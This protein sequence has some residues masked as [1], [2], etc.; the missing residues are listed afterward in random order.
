MATRLLRLR[1]ADVSLRPRG[2]SARS[3]VVT[4]VA[5]ALFA[6][7][8][9]S[10][11]AA[12]EL[13]QETTQQSDTSQGSFASRSG[14][15]VLRP[16]A[17]SRAKS[18]DDS[19][20]QLRCRTESDWLA[21]SCLRLP[22]SGARASSTD[23]GIGGEIYL[24]GET[25][26]YNIQHVKPNGTIDSHKLVLNGHPTVCGQNVYYNLEVV[27]GG[28]RHHCAGPGHYTLIYFY[29]HVIGSNLFRVLES[30]IIV[31][32]E[33]FEVMPA[34]IERTDGAGQLGIVN[35]KLPKPFVV[36]LRDFEGNV[37]KFPIADRRPNYV[38]TIA[39]P[40]GASGATLSPA[41]PAPNNMG[42]ATME[43]YL[44]NKVGA[45]TVSLTHPSA[46]VPVDFVAFAQE[47]VEPEHDATDEEEDGEITDP[48]ESRADPISIATGNNHHVETDYPRS[49]LSPL[50]FRRA[51]NSLGAKSRLTGNHWT[52]T[53]DR[54]V[55]A[56]QSAAEPLRL[57]RPDGRTIRFSN[58]AG[59]LVAQPHF[60]GRLEVVSGGWRY[61]DEQG[62][63]ETFD[64]AGKLLSIADLHGRTQTVAYDRR[65]GRMATVTT[66]TGESL[67]FQYNTKGRLSGLTDHTGRVWTYAYDAWVNL[68]QVK[69]PDGVYRTHHHERSGN[70]WLLTGVSVGRSA[71]PAGVDRQVSWSYDDAGRAT[72]NHLHNG[73]AEL[74]RVNVTYFPDGTR[75][76]DYADGS[77]ESFTTVVANGRTWVGAVRGPAFGSTGTSDLQ[78]QFDPHMNVLSS[79]RHGRSTAFGPYDSKRQPAFRIDAA[80]TPLERRADFSY[81]ARFIRRPT[82]VTEPSVVAGRQRVTEISYDARGNITR[83]TTRGYRPDGAAVTRTTT[84]QYNGP[85]GQLS[86]VDGPRTDV[87][88]ITRIDYNATTQRVSRVS[89]PNGLVLRDNITHSATGKV[90][91]ELRPNGLSIVYDYQPGSDL[92][93]SMTQTKGSAVRKTSWTYSDRRFV[94]S[95]TFADG[96]T[97]SQV[98][99][100]TYNAAGKLTSMAAPTGESVVFTLDAKGNVDYEASKAGATTR[101][102][103]DRTFDAYNRVDR[104]IS[105]NNTL[106]YDYKSDGTLDSVLD[107]RSNR[108]SY[109]YDDFKRLTRVIEPGDSQTALEYDVHG[110]LARVVDPNQGT[111]TYAFDDLGNR[112]RIQSPDAGV[113]AY[114]Y[115]DA[116]NVVRAIDATGQ[117]TRFTYDA[118]NRLKAIDRAGVD[119][120]ETHSYDTCVNG[121]GLLCSIVGGNGETVA[122]EYDGF[123]RVSRQ[124]TPAGSIGYSYNGADKVLRVT[125]PSGRSVVQEIDAAGKVTAVRVDSNGVQAALATG[126]T[127]EPFGPAKSW[128]YGNG[129]AHT[130]GYDQQYWLRSMQS[131]G[132]SVLAYSQFDRSS[133]PT[134]YSIDGVTRQF[135]YDAR[136]RLETATGPFGSRGYGYDAN[137]NRDTL[138]IDSALSDYAYEPNSNRLS[139]ETGWVYTLDAKGNVVEKRKANGEAVGSRF[140]FSVHNRLL[141]V[142]DLAAPSQPVATYRYN[143]LGQ[144]V[145]KTVAGVTTRY[146]YGRRG[147]LLAERNGAGEIVQE[148]AYLN[149]QPLALLGRPS[150]P[151][152][153]PPSF[154]QAQDNGPSSGDWSSRSDQKAFGGTYLYLE[155]RANTTSDTHSWTWSLGTA[156]NYDLY[157]WWVPPNNAGISSQTYRLNGLDATANGAGVARG[158]WLRVGNYSLP[159]GNT[160]LT[161]AEP[162]ATPKL[163]ADAARLVLT[164]PT[165]NA[166]DYAYV[167][168]DHL[169]TPIAVTN[170]TRLVVWRATHDP[171][172]AATVQDDVDGDGNHLTLNLRFP[173]QYADAESGLHYNYFRTYDPSLGRFLESDPLGLA[174]GTNTYAYVGGNP[175]SAI[176][177]L[178]LDTEHRYDLDSWLCDQGGPGCDFQSIIEVLD[179]YSV[180]F[181]FDPQEGRLV[182]GPLGEL[183]GDPI[184]HYVDRDNHRVLNITDEGHTFHPGQVVHYLELGTRSQFDLLS[185]ESREIP[186]IDLHTVGTGSGPYPWVNEIVG[187]VLFG[188]TH[189]KVQ[190]VIQS[191]R[192]R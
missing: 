130:R 45:Y 115:D 95:I 160:T 84:Y 125:Y 173:G 120:D 18:H 188:W 180:P 118:A 153:P 152:G 151:S 134:Q 92:L 137:G 51:Y 131:P 159:A 106:D 94:T 24:D 100:F 170:A 128:T 150:G 121:N 61:T 31:H 104:V 25:P 184:F 34:T 185:W 126:I 189:A 74:E 190:S 88:D 191:R 78:R 40:N 13:R 44:G 41:T 87:A 147:E 158:T 56:P 167:H 102:F 127:Y 142:F 23:Y 145:G 16:A 113:T 19:T 20:F 83:R 90:K 119:Q 101:R 99:T 43:F 11:R 133:N 149:G 37:V 85:L 8:Q 63:V 48:D 143:A 6:A 42:Q 29:E 91:S 112:V 140:E 156:G 27:L 67:T 178:G 171:F 81:D 75:D 123:G 7:A 66:N 186:T 132:V 33:P 144:R 77:R 179:D 164:Q 58:S 122:F 105:A 2:A 46:S 36:T 146:V 111:T 141:S 60:L 52:T 107:G 80:G 169:G 70:P 192:N 54:Y 10:V 166:T 114:E 35:T 4:F 9:P 17:D 97:T 59:Q 172:G 174:A 30:D 32:E 79:S 181:V 162:A 103:I 124:A 14:R 53:F 98:T 26:S 5:L 157:V 116:G 1:D 175:L 47:E 21:G 69:G 117:I 108:T 73:A 187:Q 93:L 148:Y 135:S 65:S 154:D 177:P 110:R 129:L 182:I 22:S 82:L 68:T 3:L 62:T 89:N 76:V 38:A 39:M 72:S 49:G 109:Q 28:V 15:I 86:L 183:F 96:A 64:A 57:R 161:L 176:D 138:M 165:A 55:I 155:Q 139:S 136:N 50:E 168:V 12:A 71:A 163:F